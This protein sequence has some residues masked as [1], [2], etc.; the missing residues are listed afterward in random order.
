MAR[1]Q[2]YGPLDRI[3]GT[4]DSSQYDQRKGS[5]VGKAWDLIQD[6][7]DAQAIKDIND[8]QLGRLIGFSQSNFPTWRNPKTIPP[9]ETIGSIA[10]AIQQDYN[11]VYRAFVEDTRYDVPPTEEEI[12][13]AKAA[14]KGRSQGRELRKH[15]GQVGEESQ[16]DPDADDGGV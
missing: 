3:S 1:R 11:T 13:R 2:V 10:K 16:I 14:R 5:I 8:A 6:W 12:D 7:L 9:R 15:L 4:A